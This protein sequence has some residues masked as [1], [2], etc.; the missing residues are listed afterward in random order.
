MIDIFRIFAALYSSFRNKKQLHMRSIPTITKNLLIINVLAFMA[1]YVLNPRFADLNNVFGLHFFLASDFHPFQLITYMFMHANLEHIFFNMFA[2]WMFG[3]I[4][5]RVWGPKKFIFYYISCGIGAG[6]IQELT[7]FISLYLMMANSGYDVSLMQLFSLSAADAQAL[8]AWT[9]VGASGAIYAVLLAFGMLF[10]EERMFIF[11]LPVPIKAKWFISA[12]IVIELFSALATKGDNVAHFAHLGGM[13]FGFLMIRYWRKGSNLSG[14][15]SGDSPLN[16]FKKH[17]EKHTAKKP[18]ET[19]RTRQ[20][21]DWEYNARKKEE[22]EEVDRILD[23]IRRSGYDS[24]TKEE[25]RRL[26]ENSRN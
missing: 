22:Q 2:L 16:K 17:W 24:L 12:Y 26:F 19:T 9:T 3:S 25:K 21:T 11:P 14:I 8:N 15:G 4:V 20:E 10:P 18:D 6:L 13:L 5:E 7:Q 23:K 1:Y